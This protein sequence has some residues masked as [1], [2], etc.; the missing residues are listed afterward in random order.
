ML[1]NICFILSFLLLSHTSYAVIDKRENHQ[2]QS[3][4]MTY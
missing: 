1:K 3:K 4:K 2:W